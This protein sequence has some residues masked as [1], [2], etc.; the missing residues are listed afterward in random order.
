MCQGSY[1][2]WWKKFKEFSRSFQGFFSKIQGD[3]SII[4][5]QKCNEP[6]WFT[7]FWTVTWLLEAQELS[8]ADMKL[9]KGTAGALAVKSSLRFLPFPW[10]TM[11]D[12]PITFTSIT[13]LHTRQKHAYL[14][15]FCSSSPPVY[16]GFNNHNELNTQFPPG[17]FQGSV[18]EDKPRG[19]SNS[20]MEINSGVRASVRE[21][22]IFACSEVT[23]SC[24]S[25][26]LSVTRATCTVCCGL[27]R[28]EISRSFQGARA[29]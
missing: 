26:V 15:P 21:G 28:E 11:A 25:C 24:V 14:F 3:I 29:I 19:S 10:L 6:C 23:A 27:T 17:I 1:S 13:F 20:E 4:N 16:S 18:G 9:V 22:I 12:S 7:D 2:K 5:R 8:F